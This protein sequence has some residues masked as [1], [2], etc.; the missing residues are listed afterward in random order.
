MFIDI[1]L[2]FWFVNIFS[3]FFVFSVVI[4]KNIFC[5]LCV[6]HNIIRFTLHY[7]IFP[8]LITFQVAF[9]SIVCNS[10]ASTFT[11]ATC[12]GITFSQ[13][14]PFSALRSSFSNTMCSFTWYPW[15]H[16]TSAVSRISSS[17]LRFTAKIVTSSASSL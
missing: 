7:L 16:L 4:P 5:L 8:S 3:L 15:K 12:F 6:F 13:S 17:R 2:N 1:P 10:P 14:G 9:F 11:A